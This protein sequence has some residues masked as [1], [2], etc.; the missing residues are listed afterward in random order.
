MDEDDL[1][2]AMYDGA[3]SD[4][5]TIYNVTADMLGAEFR[6]K[7]VGDGG[8]RYY[9]E[10]AT[11]AAE[12]GVAR[13]GR[14]I[15]TSFSFAGIAPNPVRGTA[16]IRF[17]LPRQSRVRLAVYS[18]DGREIICLKNGLC[19]AGFH[20]VPWEG[21]TGAG[22]PAGQGHYIVR[23]EAGDKIRRQRFVLTR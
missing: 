9:S 6:V 15:P 7:I 19:Q 11:L 10:T 3:D 13:R 18:L 4:T 23:I 20:R 2:P 22:R 5:L 14:A 16:F 21:I 8:K 17:A 12:V 1:S